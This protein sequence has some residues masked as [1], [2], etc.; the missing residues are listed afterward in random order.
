ME[1]KVNMP[2]SKDEEKGDRSGFSYEL[3]L[4]NKMAERERGEGKR[5]A[6]PKYPPHHPVSHKV[7][8]SQRY[9]KTFG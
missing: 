5:L 1:D 9:K 2:R 7:S 8:Q 4:L 6:T 3:T